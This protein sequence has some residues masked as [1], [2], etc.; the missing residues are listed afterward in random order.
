MDGRIIE[1]STCE[2]EICTGDV[3]KVID[4]KRQ[5]MVDRRNFLYLSLFP[6]TVKYND[7]ELASPAS[8]FG[9]LLPQIV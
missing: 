9:K 8:E 7:C 3:G 6:L 4:T 1:E 2:K 5:C